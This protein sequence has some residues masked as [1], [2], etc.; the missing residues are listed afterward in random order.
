MNK[1]L[2]VIEYDGKESLS[3]ETLSE[4]VINMLDTYQNDNTFINVM[5]FATV[6]M[7][8][9][10]YNNFDNE[11]EKDEWQYFINDLAEDDDELIDKLYYQGIYEQNIKF[12]AQCF[13]N[14]ISERGLVTFE[15]ATAVIN[16]LEMFDSDCEKAYYNILEAAEDDKNNSYTALQKHFKTVRSNLV[17]EESKSVQIK[18]NEN[19]MMW[20]NSIE[21]QVFEGTDYADLK[22]SK[23]IIMLVK[24]FFE[25]TN[26]EWSISDLL[27]IKTAMVNIGLMPKTKVNY[28]KFLKDIY[29]NERLKEVLLGENATKSIE[30]QHSMSTVSVLTKF[31]MLKTDESYV[32]DSVV[33]LLSEYGIKIDKRKIIND[34][35]HKYALNELHINYNSEIEVFDL[36]VD[37]LYNL[38]QY[39]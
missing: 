38:K 27:S 19:V 32:V 26:G 34:L 4:K 21:Y 20:V 29:D 11:L 35:V 33:E 1:L 7:L 23:K 31:D 12:A 5:T 10:K 13:L 17:R 39:R 30:F 9:L 37:L 18:H 3:R 22:D 2:E 15:L 16:R 8:L 28:E 36:I 24:D 6:D 25:I 14:L